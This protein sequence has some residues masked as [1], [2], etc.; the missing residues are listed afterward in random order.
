MN[1]YGGPSSRSSVLA[2][3]WERV[4]N[5]AKDIS[6]AISTMIFPAIPRPSCTPILLRPNCRNY[7]L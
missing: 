7:L 6:R 3:L 2:V 4:L 5:V 1:C